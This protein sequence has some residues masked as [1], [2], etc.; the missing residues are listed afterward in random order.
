MELKELLSQQN[1]LKDDIN[2]QTRIKNDAES[3]FLFEKNNLD[4][5]NND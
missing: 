4:T 2:E 1:R 3:N 5:K